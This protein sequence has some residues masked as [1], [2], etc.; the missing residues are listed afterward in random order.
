MTEEFDY[1]E[2]GAGTLYGTK[3]RI[4]LVWGAREV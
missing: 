2:K 3:H 1:G 4:T